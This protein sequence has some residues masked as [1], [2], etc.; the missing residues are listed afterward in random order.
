M[1]NLHIQVVLYNSSAYIPK[2]IGGLEL[3]VT[4]SITVCIH[5]LNNSQNREDIELIKKINPKFNYTIDQNTQNQ[6]FG[7]AHN[8][9]FDE[10]K[11]EYDE[12][13]L[14]LNPDTLVFFNLLEEFS[15]FIKKI[16]D[17]WGAIELKQFPHEHPKVYNKNFETDWVSG[18]ACFF[19]TEIFN[20]LKGFDDNIFMYCED[21]DLSWR[22]LDKGYKIYHCPFAKVTHLNTNLLPDRDSDF[23]VFY[24]LVGGLYLRYKYSNNTAYKSFKKYIQTEA[25][26][27]DIRKEVFN[28]FN[29]MKTNLT[30]KE[31]SKYSKCKYDKFYNDGNYAKHR[32]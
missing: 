29:Q 32:W 6:G 27:K 22:L 7:K 20:K 8:N 3:L 31:I 16:P 13:F 4:N 17:N 24:S 5:F 14:I 15:K 18:A 26:F 21:I 9:L 1:K 12:Y 19:K 23:E 2:L 11:S 25:K 30:N 28:E 10:Y